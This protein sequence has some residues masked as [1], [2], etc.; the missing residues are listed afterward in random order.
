MPLTDNQFSALV[1]FCFNVGV[2]A[3]EDSTLLE[4]LNQG[5]FIGASN[6]FAQWNKVNGEPWLDLTR[7]RLAEQALFSGRPWKQF[8]TYV[9]KH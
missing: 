2:G 9:E 5:D 8:L 3:F 7:R 4:L 6:Q 1:C